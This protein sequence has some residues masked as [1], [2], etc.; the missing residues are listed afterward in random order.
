[1]EPDLVVQ[2]ALLSPLI[3]NVVG[4]LTIRTEGLLGKLG[5]SSSGW[6]NDT[7][8]EDLTLRQVFTPG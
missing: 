2:N 3:A 1:M 8:E 6:A 4:V 7:E 5:C